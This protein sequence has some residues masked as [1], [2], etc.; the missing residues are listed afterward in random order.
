MGTPNSS[1]TSGI[2]S[3]ISPAPAVMPSSTRGPG[4]DGSVASNH[5]G[6]VPHGNV[7]TSR[8]GTGPSIHSTNASVSRR[9]ANVAGVGAGGYLDY[10]PGN[11]VTGA[12]GA[13]VTTLPGAA[14]FSRLTPERR[15]IHSTKPP[16]IDYEANASNTGVSVASRCINMAGVNSITWTSPNQTPGATGFTFFRSLTAKIGRRGPVTGTVGGGPNLPGVAEDS[17]SAVLISA[18]NDRSQTSQT[19]ASGTTNYTPEED[20]SSEAVTLNTGNPVDGITLGPSPGGSPISQSETRR[21]IY[22]DDEDDERCKPRSLRFTWSIRTTSHL[23]PM[24]IIREIE[25]V[26]SENNCVYEQ[27]NKFLVVCD[28]GNPSTDANVHW[29]MEVCRL[30]RLSMNAVRFKRISGTAVAHKNIA[31]RI[32]DQMKL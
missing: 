15:T 24:E 12:G 30:P 19:S 7:S 9:G 27:Q 29:E 25:R 2:G 22:D 10:T 14:A 32:A 13:P 5:S 4:G 6:Y 18:D 23:P 1:N 8:S 20:H 26:L 21:R 17:N 16:N 11:V 28:Y 3:A 31:H